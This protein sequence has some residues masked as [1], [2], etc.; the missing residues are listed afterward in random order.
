M[1]FPGNQLFEAGKNSQK[2]NIYIYKMLQHTLGIYCMHYLVGNIIILVL[3]SVGYEPDGFV[4]SIC[5]YIICYL[6]S[7]MISKIPIKQL[8]QLVD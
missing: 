3:E 8:R 5:I 7:A 6:A 1:F 2:I 4:L